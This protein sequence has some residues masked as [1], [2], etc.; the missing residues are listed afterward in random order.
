MRGARLRLDE[1]MTILRW[2]YA[3][4]LVSA[5]VTSD[6]IAQ[7]TP[8]GPV[9]P[10]AARRAIVGTVMDTSHQVLENV[11]VGINKPRRQAKTNAQGRFTLTDLD[12]GTY[13]VSVYK[14]GYET[15]VQA[16][17][18]ADTGGIARFCLIPE[19]RELPAI[20]ASAKRLGL[21]GV[22]GDSNY[23]ALEGAEVRVMGAGLHT[24]TDST[25]AFHLAVPKGTYPVWISKPGFARKMVSVTIPADSG[26][27][28]AVWLGSPLP[29]ANAV[30]AKI[31]DMRNRI[32]W[33][34]P[35]RSALISAEQ[36]ARSS[37]SLNGILLARAKAPVREDCLAHIDGN[38][39]SGIPLYMI[40]KD[41][42]LMMEIYLAGSPRTAPTS[43][44]PAGSQGGKSITVGTQSSGP[45]SG[46]QCGS[47]WVWLKR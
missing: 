16:Y 31:D 21:S 33:A 41:D 8:G 29:D 36:I 28:I 24:L 5:F 27:D 19:P 30:A 43:I 42:V 37:A 35:N 38:P 13:E 44:H 14:I 40:D 9:N 34:R 11:T 2:T 26:R 4:G 20:I 45:P 6:A 22:I 23:N 39:R 32:L 25:G 7:C 47:I 1:T 17:V 12:T 46:S 10:V 3:A 18:V 15:A